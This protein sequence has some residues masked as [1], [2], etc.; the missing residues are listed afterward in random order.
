MRY[1]YNKMNDNDDIRNFAKE[2]VMKPLNANGVSPVND[3]VKGF[4]EGS[5]GSEYKRVNPIFDTPIQGGSAYP[6]S[7]QFQ[8]QQN[9]NPNAQMEQ[10]MRQ[11]DCTLNNQWS[12]DS[13]KLIN[14]VKTERGFFGFIAGT[15][16]W[17]FFERKQTHREQNN[18]HGG[19]TQLKK[20][21]IKDYLYVILSGLSR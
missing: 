9:Y 1:L 15:Q 7:G 8:P 13:Y 2:Y 16:E 14:E 18:L 17:V 20:L 3:V 10:L 12:P 4:A 11:V 6:M 21:R 19:I 5:M